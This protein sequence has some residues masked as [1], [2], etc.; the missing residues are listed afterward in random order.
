MGYACTL[1]ATWPNLTQHLILLWNP[2][3]LSQSTA[4]LSFQLH[5][6]NVFHGQSYHLRHNPHPPHRSSLLLLILPRWTRPSTD[7]MAPPIPLN[8]GD[9]LHRNPRDYRPLVRLAQ[10]PKLQHHTAPAGYSPLRPR[11]EQRH[12][13]LLQLR[14]IQ[15]VQ[16][17]SAW[18]GYS[19]PQLA[20]RSWV[21]GSAPRGRLPLQRLEQGRLS[22]VLWR[23]CHQEAGSLG[24]LHR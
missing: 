19:P 16:K 13:L 24:L 21:S 23:C 4:E 11:M 2:S 8:S 5:H 15:R 12:L 14:L 17:L 18:S 6:S 10:R 20:R 7:P 9:E 1:E 22:S 3:V